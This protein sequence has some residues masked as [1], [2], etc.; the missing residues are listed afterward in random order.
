MYIYTYIQ[1]MYL[2]PNTWLHLLPTSVYLYIYIYKCIYIY[3]Y[4]YTYIQY[5]YLLPNTWL[6]LLSTSVLKSNPRYHNYSDKSY[7]QNLHVHI[8]IWIYTYMY[9][10]I[11]IHMYAYVTCIHISTRNC[12]AAIVDDNNVCIHTC[13]SQ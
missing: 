3:M 13:I 5:M 6:H 4:I 12:N 1:Y 2:L 10:Y 7:N 8:C 11:Y 9:I